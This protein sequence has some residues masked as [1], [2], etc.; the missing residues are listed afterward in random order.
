MASKISSYYNHTGSS[1]EQNLVEDLIIETIQHRGITISYILRSGT[2][3]HLWNEQTNVKFAEQDKIEMYIEEMNEFDGMGDMFSGFGFEIPD[4]AVFQV[5]I[6]RFKE[7]FELDYGLTSPRVG[8]LIYLPFADMYY[9]ITNVMKDKDFYQKG[10][11]YTH[12]LKVDKF[13]FG[14]EDITPPTEDTSSFTDIFEDES[15]G[16]EEDPI[17]SSD[18]A[19][20]DSDTIQTEANDSIIFDPTNFQF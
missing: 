7:E 5:S 1:P 17:E 10:V 6:K 3:D 20:D 4:N 11:S 8:D 16:L 9:E 12:R 2:D 14:H 19:G 18:I 15:L 13:T